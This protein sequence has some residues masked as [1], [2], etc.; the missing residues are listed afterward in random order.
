MSENGILIDYKY[1][2]GC[3]S[4][5]L[6]CKNEKGLSIGEWGIKVLQMGPF[7]KKPEGI[8]WNYF[9]MP[10]SHCDLCKDRVAEGDNV[11]ACVLH[12]LAGVMEYGPL[13]M[14]TKKMKEKGEKA[15]LFIP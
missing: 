1:C 8:E 7:E 9:P 14:L 3:Q 13:D 5:E 2:S 4:C 12:C 6:A 15:Y 11:P 10:T